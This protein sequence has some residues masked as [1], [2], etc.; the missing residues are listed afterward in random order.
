MEEEIKTE[1]LVEPEEPE[2]IKRE[3]KHVD[4]NVWKP[5]TALGRKVKDG[6]ITDISQILDKGIKILES[7][8]VDILVPDIEKELLLVGQSKGKFGGGQ[9]RIFKQTQKKTK[10]GNVPK[11]STIAVVGNKNGY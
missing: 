9:R 1:I 11:F 3:E 5:K 10:D 2:V 7:E 6:T 8:I 4:K